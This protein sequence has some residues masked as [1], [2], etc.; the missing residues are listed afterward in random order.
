MK[1]KKTTDQTLSLL[2]CCW[3]SL[4]FSNK[5]P[6]PALRYGVKKKIKKIKIK[7]K[8]KIKQTD[9]PTDRKCLACLNACVL[10]KCQLKIE[11]N[12]FARTNTVARAWFSLIFLLLPPRLRCFFLFCF[13]V[14]RGGKLFFFSF[15]LFSGLLLFFLHLVI[16]LVSGVTV[17]R[18]LGRRRHARAFSLL[19]SFFF[20]ISSRFFFVP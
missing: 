12:W 20:L 7:G 14:P 15:F 11:G 17:S 2:P 4:I 6:L 13:R 18:R 1:V 9:R 16:V 5:R 10:F 19:L 3:W 8:E